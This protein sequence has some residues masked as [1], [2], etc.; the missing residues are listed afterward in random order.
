MLQENDFLF[1]KEPKGLK[2]MFLPVQFLG[3]VFKKR[4]A[5]ESKKIR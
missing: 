2:D 3:D 1:I 5:K 4:K